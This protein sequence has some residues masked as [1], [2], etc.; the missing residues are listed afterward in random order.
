MKRLISTIVTLSL[1][2]IGIPASANDGLT[3]TSVGIPVLAPGGLTVT[4]NSLQIIEKT[5]STQLAINYSQ[6]NNT[7]DK[8]LD[9]GSFKLFFTDGSSEPQ[10]GFFN[11]FFPADGNSRSYTWEWL[12]GK[13]PWLI[14][15]E[16]GFFASKPTPAGLKWKVGTAFPAATPITTP[17]PVPVTTPSPVPIT[18]PSPVPSSPGTPPVVTLK[19]TGETFNLSANGLGGGGDSLSIRS[20]DSIYWIQEFFGQPTA[21]YKF[22]LTPRAGMTWESRFFDGATFVPASFQNCA[23]VWKVFDGGIAKSST[24]KNRGAKA[25]KK[26][27]VFKTGYDKSM[28]LDSDRDGLVCER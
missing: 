7:A 25:S 14:E 13:E 24:S 9:E 18:T 4:L 3:Y 27:T 8:K 12:K 20:G 1:M 11:S 21:N 2:A 17:S 23:Q 5:G 22:R 6:R 16:A 19:W 26:A 28:K 15:W 10:Y